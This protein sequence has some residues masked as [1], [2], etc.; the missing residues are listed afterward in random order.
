[1]VEAECNDAI[2]EN[3]CG[4]L[5]RFLVFYTITLERPHSMMVIIQW[6][7]VRPKDIFPILRKRCEVSF[8]S[9]TEEVKKA[10][11]RIDSMCPLPSIF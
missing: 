4:T 5:F 7:T 8:P 6:D 3:P 9:R 1:M 10:N 2:Q 11:I